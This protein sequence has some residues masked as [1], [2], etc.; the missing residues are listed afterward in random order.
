MKVV[1]LSVFVI[2]TSCIFCFA[3]VIDE[4]KNIDNQMYQGTI[5]W[6]EK[7][8]VGNQEKV[9]I[10]NYNIY[11][12]Q[13]TQHNETF[14]KY[15]DGKDAF[16]VD[17]KDELIKFDSST[18]NSENKTAFVCLATKPSYCYGRGLSELNNV[19][20]NTSINVLTGYTKGGNKTIA[21]LDPALDYIAHK[22]EF[23]EPNENKLKVIIEN[24]NPILVDG[25]YYIYSK[26][27]GK[28][29]SDGGGIAMSIDITS[30]TFK[31]PETKDYTYDWKTSNLDIADARPGNRYAYFNRSQ[32][33]KNITSEQLLKMSTEFIENQAKM[34]A[35]I[36]KKLNN[37]SNK[38][39]NKNPILISL[40]ILMILLFAVMFIKNIR[41]INIKND[42]K[43]EN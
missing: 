25:K 41:R 23:Y 12:V 14:N 21:H 43:R 8:V 6:K 35:D 33:P 7:S 30:A 16:F 42:E 18:K 24:S 19:S 11:Q 39:K 32:I 9:L 10:Y 36:D 38:N 5:K 26:S 4:I 15:Y 29:T 22:I 17:K 40:S 1:I 3:D 28:F 2:F 13:L 27:R 37:N 34:V 31:K 20:F